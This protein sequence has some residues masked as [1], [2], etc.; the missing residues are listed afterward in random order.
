MAEIFQKNKSFFLEINNIINSNIQKI[1]P[2]I[3]FRHLIVFC[4]K[5]L[6]LDFINTLNLIAKLTN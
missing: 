3:Q 6:N 5:G 1:N 4:G 2:E